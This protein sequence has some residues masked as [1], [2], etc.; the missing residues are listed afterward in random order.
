MLNAV[1]L[2]DTDGEQRLSS[3]ELFV[4]VGAAPNL[5]FMLRSSQLI[6]CGSKIKRSIAYWV[7]NGG[8]ASP[9][10]NLPT[11]FNTNTPR[12][13][14]ACGVLGQPDQG[15]QRSVGDD[16]R[17][18]IVPTHRNPLD[19][20]PDHIARRLG[21][22][23]IRQGDSKLND[24]APVYL[25]QVRIEPYR[26]R[27]RAGKLGVKGLDPAAVSSQWSAP[28]AQIHAETPATVCFIRHFL[29]LQYNRSW[30]AGSSNF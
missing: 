15:C 1:T 14:G 19:Q 2:Q 29:L 26:S 4:I 28:A 5:L 23:R 30:F 10:P 18:S 27:G 20:T 7:G 25:R 12:S 9:Q 11:E 8:C 21:D 24:L 16:H 3:K 13:R 22:R 6:A 17:L